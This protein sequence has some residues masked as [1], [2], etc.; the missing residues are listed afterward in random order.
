[1][2]AITVT[3]AAA[4]ASASGRAFAF[5]PY[6]DTPLYPPLNLKTAARATGVRYFSLAFVLSGGGCKASWGG[7]TAV[8]DERVILPQ[9]CT[10]V[11]SP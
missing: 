7:V 5:A 1:M 6:V 9:L 10:T 11:A 4:P 3:V 2:A 8:S